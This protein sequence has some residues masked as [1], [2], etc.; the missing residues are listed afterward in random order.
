MFELHV[1]TRRSDGLGYV[2]NTQ[3]APDFSVISVFHQLHCLYTL[4]RAYFAE[5]AGDKELQD[6]DFGHDRNEHAGHCFE[7]L[8]QSLMCSA[9]SSVEPAHVEKKGGQEF[10]GW[11]VP[12]MCRNYDQLKNW[13]EE[14]RAFDAHGFLAND[15]R[16]SGH[17]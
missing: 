9:D 11:D 16:G 2:N 3:I 7:Y 17:E 14:R 10:L 6:F 8:R 5:Q 13:A 12:R 1:L 15:L 4:R